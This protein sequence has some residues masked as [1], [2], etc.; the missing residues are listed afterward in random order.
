MLYDYPVNTFITPQVMFTNHDWKNYVNI[1]HVIWTNCKE[2][3]NLE[4]F[5]TCQEK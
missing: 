3:S 4:C 2:P 5:I 1:N